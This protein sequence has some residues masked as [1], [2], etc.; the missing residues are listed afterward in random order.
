MGMVIV[1]I[2]QQINSP[3][4]ADL[5]A[6]NKC[7]GSEIG[8]DTSSIPLCFRPSQNSSIPSVFV[9]PTELYN[10]TNTILFCLVLMVINFIVF[11]ACLHPKYKRVES[12]KISS[13]EKSIMV[14]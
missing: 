6:I 7:G 2:G 5:I 13:F 11:V 10:A 4:S 1:L 9:K 14:K 8:N 12:E 3:L